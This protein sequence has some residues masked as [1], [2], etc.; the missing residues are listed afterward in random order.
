MTDIDALRDQFARDG[1]VRIPGLLDDSEVEHYRRL[2]Q[3]ASG[4]EDRAFHPSV[5]KRKIWGLPDGVTARREFWPLIF[6]PGLLDAVRAVVGDDARYTQHSD[7][8][9]NR[10]VPGWHRDSACRTFG[11]GPDWDESQEPYRIVRVAIYLQSHRDSSSKLGLIPGSHRRESALQRLELRALAARN[12]LRDKLGRPAHSGRLLLVKP[13]WV[14][15]DPGD[16]LIFDQRV[17][18][19]ASPITGPKYAIFLS[20]GGD[21][22]HSRNHRRYYLFQRGDLRYDDYPPELADQL[23]ERGLFLALD[24]G[25]LEGAASS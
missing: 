10:G 23:R 25:E 17:I 5:S 13:Q 22:E 20:Y 4:L 24:Q 6:N 11:V 18:H 9:V 21:D 15:T 3:E 16:C 7:L 14:R 12:R 8:H 19:S 2:I 1:Y